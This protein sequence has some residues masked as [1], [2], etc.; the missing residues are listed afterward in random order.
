[1]LSKVSEQQTI[2]WY[3]YDGVYL[4]MKIENYTETAWSTK[5]PCKCNQFYLSQEDDWSEH[6][7]NYK[8]SNRNM[9]LIK[10]NV[11]STQRCGVPYC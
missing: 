10:W 2:I 6:S 3:S 7:M 9:L 4:I 8:V 11:V 1:M 5:H